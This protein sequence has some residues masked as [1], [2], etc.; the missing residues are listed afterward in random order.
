M[1][2]KAV[3]EVILVV[4]DMRWVP[5]GSCSVG[6]VRVVAQEYDDVVPGIE[7]VPH[8]DLVASAAGVA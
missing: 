6:E 8:A 2:A 7:S 3:A 1:L 5:C 4:M